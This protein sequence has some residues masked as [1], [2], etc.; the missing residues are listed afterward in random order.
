MAGSYLDLRICAFLDQLADRQPAPGGGSAAA[1]AAG[2]AAGLV[3]M[4]A[5]F[6]AAQLPD[7][8]GV[9]ARADRLRLRAGALADADARAYQAVLAASS[10]PAEDAHRRKAWREATRV[11]LELSTVGAETAELAASVL[12]AGNPNLRGDASTAA[13]LAGAV[14]RS[15]AELVSLNV[16]ASGGD[17]EPV[18]RAARNV[19]AAQAA[20]RA[21]GLGA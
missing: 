19:E 6:S 12:R 21:A 11:P 13:L 2:L 3:A 8:A 20:L 5:R 4:A 10:D 16:A 14:V 17:D 1:V 15:A 7:H 18:R 9:A